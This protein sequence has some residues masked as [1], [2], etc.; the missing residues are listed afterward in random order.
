MVTKTG[1]IQ[2][3]T[4]VKVLDEVIESRKFIKALE[5][6]TVNFICH[7]L[8]R[9]EFVTSIIEGKVLGKKGRGRAKEAL[10]CG[11]QSSYGDW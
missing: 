3:N 2:S 10:S 5:G 9:N 11:Y 8:R 6:N 4:N 7:L 1:W